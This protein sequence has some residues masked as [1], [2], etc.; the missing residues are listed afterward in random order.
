MLARAA[1]RTDDSAAATLIRVLLTATAYAVLVVPSS[2]VRTLLAA[3]G[4]ATRTVVLD[5]GLA[6]LTGLVVLAAAQLLVDGV[7]GLR[8]GGLVGVRRARRIALVSLTGGALVLGITPAQGATDASVPATPATQAAVAAC[9][10][11]SADRTYDIAAINVDIPYNR[12][13]QRNPH[14]MVYA[15]QSDKVAIRDWSRPLGTTSSDRRLRPRP[16]VVRANEGECV[17]VNFSNELGENPGAGLPVNPRASIS[18]KGLPYDVQTSGGSHAGL[19]RRHHGRPRPEPDLLLARAAGGHLLLPRHRDARRLRGRRRQRPAGLYGALVVEPAGSTWRDPRTG[20]ELYTQTGSQSGDLYLDAVIDPAAGRT[21]RETVQLAQDEMP[22][23]SG[24]AFNYGSE[25]IQNRDENRC[26]DC[27]GEETSLSSWAY[28]DPAMVK[29]ASGLGPWEPGTPEGAEDCG[30]ERPGFDADSCFTSNVSHA[31]AK[32]P[33]KFRYGMAGGR[34]THVFHMHAHQWLA[35]DEDTGAAGATP[36]QPSTTAKPESQTIDSQTFGPD[37]MFTADLLF[38]AGSKPGTVGDSIFHCHLYPHFAAGF[39]ALLRVHDVVEDGTGSTPDGIRV[40][41]LLPLADTEA[42]RR[43][44]RRQPGLPA[45]HPRRARLARPAAPA[46]RPR[47]RR[48]GPPLRRGFRA[49]R[50]VR[51]GG[52]GDGRPEPALRRRV[53]ARCAV[54]RP[55]PHRVPGGHLQGVGHPDRHRLQRARRPRHP[56]PHP[57]PRQRRGRG[58]GRHE[59]AGTAVRPR[60]RG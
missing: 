17:R 20:R 51:S 52:P 15:L 39:W 32:D 35:D 31:Y 27:I 4:T 37:E 50:A 60:Q 53:Q 47:R 25:P 54:Q 58:P 48:P 2:Q 49:G 55:L 26:G 56:G 11:A 8:S 30:L 23:T 5:A 33:V 6:L 7:V 28:G 59:G 1:G 9:D 16:L 57:G 40:P 45:V 29:L 34:E 18:I 19:Q 24:F 21:F 43:R 38:G 44:D 36:S 10:A 13:G 42:P 3:S 14:G 22:I 41:A 12:W 46:R